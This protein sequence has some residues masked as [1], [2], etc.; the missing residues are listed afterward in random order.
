VGDADADARAPMSGLAA[1]FERTGDGLDERRIDGMLAAIDHRGPDGSGAWRGDGVALGHQQL[2]STPVASSQPRSTDELVVTA[3]ARLDNRPELGRRLELPETATDSQLLLEAYREWGEDCVTELVGAFAFV[4]W[5]RTAERLLCARDHFGV[6]PLY[7]HSTDDRFAV[8]SEPK[9]LLALPW[10]RPSLDETKVGDFLTELFEDKTNTF[11]DSIHRVQPA[12]V[13]TVSEATRTERRYWD[14]D[15]SRRVTLDS[16]GAYAR[17]FRELFERA[18]SDRLRTDRPVAA[19]LSGGLDSS[20]IT[21]VAHEQMAPDKRLRTYSGVFADSPE[22]DEREYIET[23]VDRDGIDANYVFVDDL[24]ALS[25]IDRVMRY[26]DEP[27]YNTMHYMKWEI[28]RRAS[29]DGIGVVLEGAHGDNAVDYGLGRLPELARSGRWRQ[30]VS[31]LRA[32][33]DVLDRPARA[34]FLELVVPHV[35]P[36]VATQLLDRFRSEPPPELQAN[37]AIDTDFASRIGCRARHEEL[38]QRGSALHRSARKWQYRSLMT[39]SMTSFLE[40]NDITHAAFGLEPRYPFI[41]IRL[42]EFTL[43]IPPSQ[44]L[45]GGWTRLILRRALDDVLPDPIQWRP[46]KTTMNQAFIDALSSADGQV[47]ALVDEPT[48][49]EPYLNTE[50]LTE[51]YEE[52]QTDPNMQN[53]RVLWHAL[54]LS[55]WLQQ[56]DAPGRSGQHR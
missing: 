25:D 3:D 54:S 4:V 56:S 2:Q 24:D 44:Q 41:D 38:E 28:A 5:D 8:A 6:K 51:L 33:G 48:A 11:Y 13:L 34:L 22:S 35:V 30:L 9:A 40:A 39:G 18:V 29:D 15:T 7:Y 47:A 32:M 14:L 55:V 49:V 31:E 16:D 37:P 45:Q 53:A 36:R 17:R 27:V 50:T 19:T 43:A 10:V 1:V 42:I 46:W 21:A 12:H 52:F 26:H 23:L 20:S